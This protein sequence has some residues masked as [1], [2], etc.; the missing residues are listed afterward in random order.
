MTEHT[1]TFSWSE[2]EDLLVELAQ[3]KLR[4]RHTR[5]RERFAS[6]GAELLALREVYLRAHARAY[7]MCTCGPRCWKQASD[8]AYAEMT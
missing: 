1:A 6:L 8:V 7:P 4:N 5:S 2:L 3:A